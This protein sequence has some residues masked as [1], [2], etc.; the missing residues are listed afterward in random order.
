M[1]A[2]K[3]SDHYLA[4]ALGCIENVEFIS[5]GN[6]DG[7]FKLAFPN[8]VYLSFMRGFMI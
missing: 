1:I 8:Q 3:T 5:E 2:F 4:K 6:G 7:K